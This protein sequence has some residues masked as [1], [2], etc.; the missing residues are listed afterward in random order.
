MHG[1]WPKSVKTAPPM[2][3]MLIHATMG[4]NR[5]MRRAERSREDRLKRITREGVNSPFRKEEE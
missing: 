3:P 2:S 1:N 5:A 4:E